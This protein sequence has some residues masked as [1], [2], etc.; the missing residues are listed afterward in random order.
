MSTATAPTSSLPLSSYGG[1]NLKTKYTAP[2]LEPI[3]NYLK[4]KLPKVIIIN[5]VQLENSGAVLSPVPGFPG[6]S[7]VRIM[8]NGVLAVGW[9]PPLSW[10]FLSIDL[11]NLTAS[12]ITVQTIDENGLAG[13]VSTLSPFS[14]IGW[15][16]GAVLAAFASPMAQLPD[17]LLKQ[18]AAK[19][20]T[21]DIKMTKET[22]SS[23]MEFNLPPLEWAKQYGRDFAIVAFLDSYRR[24]QLRRSRWWLNPDGVPC[25]LID[26]ALVGK[27]YADD[28]LKK[29]IPLAD[30]YW[31]NA[32]AKMTGFG[33]WTPNAFGVNPFDGMHFD[34]EETAAGVTLLGMPQN[35]FG[36]VT[37]YSA[38]RAHIGYWRTKEKNG[39]PSTHNFSGAPRMAGWRLVAGAN[40]LFA[41]AGRG[42]Q[43]QSFRDYVIA[44]CRAVVEWLEKLLS[45]PTPFANPWFYGSVPDEIK[46][47][48]LDYWQDWQ[49]AVLA[50]GLFKFA[51]ALKQSANSSA[52]VSLAAMAESLAES[53]LDWLEANVD[54]ATQRIHYI[55]SVDGSVKE[56]APIPGTG[57]WII[58]A[59]QL[60][61]KERPLLDVS[62][63]QLG[64]NYADFG[65][66]DW[67][68]VSWTGSYL[69]DAKEAKPM[70]AAAPAP[71]S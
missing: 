51:R 17:A 26:A 4:Q 24:F 40:V 49:F 35:F 5:G 67:T 71:K 69:F 21:P 48:Q 57:A 50:V 8:Q 22:G 58:P 19:I 63:E 2:G 39:S 6:W 11:F 23:N 45:F 34:T 1:T 33:E 41:A 7:M 30:V 9:L 47:K 54:P 32:S 70:P 18:L 53:T 15:T 16:E 27:P 38:A 12:N 37:L 68:S 55:R 28:T 10:Q 44:D 52:D 62:L 20:T 65:P 59:L 61:K 43:L 36:L 25:G 60:S 46:E 56:V 14:G 66:N 64:T 3:A 42:A 31:I 13:A 29:T